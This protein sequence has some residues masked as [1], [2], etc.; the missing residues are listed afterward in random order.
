MFYQ[1]SATI[2]S[3]CPCQL[4]ILLPLFLRKMLKQ[5]FLLHPRL[6]TTP[7]MQTL[8]SEKDIYLEKLPINRLRLVKVS[9]QV[10][11]LFSGW[12]ITVPLR[13]CK[14]GSTLYVYLIR[15]TCLLKPFPPLPP[16][17]HSHLESLGAGTY[18]HVCV[19]TSK[20]GIKFTLLHFAEG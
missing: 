10:S 5:S 15:T 11:F 1:G 19:P 9:F 17:Y 16:S 8:V 4:L 13:Q 3:C 7:A 20:S 2:C 12:S 6:K 18:G 14:V